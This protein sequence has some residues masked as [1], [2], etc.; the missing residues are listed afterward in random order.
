MTIFQLWNA[1]LENLILKLTLFS[2]TVRGLLGQIRYIV[3]FFQFS[4]YSVT[5]ISKHFTKISCD[6][7]I[8]NKKLG[9]LHTVCSKKE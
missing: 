4:F 2:Y 3:V 9:C 5:P 7:Q 6:R 1:H 8:L